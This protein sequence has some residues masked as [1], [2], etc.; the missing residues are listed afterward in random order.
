MKQIISKKSLILITTISLFLYL[1]SLSFA[2][3][4]GSYS[5]YKSPAPEHD[6][7]VGDE[8]QFEFWY[9]PYSE[10][11][12][13]VG[14]EY[15]PDWGPVLDLNLTQGDVGTTFIVNSG[16]AYDVFV[17]SITNGILDSYSWM[18]HSLGGSGTGGPEISLW[19]ASNHQ[20][21]NMILHIQG[22]Y[23]GLNGVDFEGFIIDHLAFHTDVHNPREFG[24]TIE[25]HGGPVP[26]PATMLLLGSGLVGLA[27]IGRKRFKK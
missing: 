10:Y 8:V 6:D 5:Y 24:F 15:V 21:E 12:E 2:L 13:I 16:E 19:T 14:G 20:E 25:V 11:G 18:Y 9:G 3:T 26:E 7:I 17:D 1:S 23:G 4:I 27:A 22:Y